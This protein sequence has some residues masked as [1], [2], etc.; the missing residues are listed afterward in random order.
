MVPHTR[1]KKTTHF[2]TRPLFS[3]LKPSYFNYDIYIITCLNF[4]GVLKLQKVDKS[5]RNTGEGVAPECPAARL[6]EA[7]LSSL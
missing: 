6:V 2:L 7:T 1:Q 4:L 5:E 3:S